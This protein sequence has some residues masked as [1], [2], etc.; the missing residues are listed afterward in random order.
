[1][2][3]LVNEN[4]CSVIDCVSFGV[5]WGKAENVGSLERT[6]GVVYLWVC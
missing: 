5:N 6:Y 4:V 1:M 3:Y 2:G